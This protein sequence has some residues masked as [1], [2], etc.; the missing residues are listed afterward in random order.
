MRR[1]RRRIC[2]DW[3]SCTSRPQRVVG[4]DGVNY[5]CFDYRD[6]LRTIGAAH[7]SRA[8]KAFQQ[9]VGEPLTARRS[10]A[11]NPRLRAPVIRCSFPPSPP[12]SQRAH[13]SLLGGTGRS[14]HD[15]YPP[16]TEFTAGTGR[17]IGNLRISRIISCLYAGI[18][19][20]AGTRR[21]AVI[22]VVV[23]CAYTL[24]DSRPIRGDKLW[25][26]EGG[27]GK[28]ISR[29]YPEIWWNPQISSL[30]GL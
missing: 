25:R 17:C 6:C 11:R 30:L 15:R 19:N 28:T 13:G 10:R 2:H 8:R 27:S 5:D 29:K 4:R 1:K 14:H 3:N 9:S 24:S 18:R 26:C 23:E 16:N 21:F 20:D 12:E 22:F 7:A